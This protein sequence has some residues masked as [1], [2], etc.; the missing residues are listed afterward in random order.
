MLFVGLVMQVGAFEKANYAEIWESIDEEGKY[1]MLIGVISSSIQDAILLTEFANSSDIRFIE[2]MDFIMDYVVYIAKYLSF[3]GED[4]NNID[5]VI[6]LVDKFYL[7]PNNKYCNVAGL[8]FISYL[9]LQGKDVSK[10]LER[11]I[12]YSEFGTGNLF[13]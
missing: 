12:Y 3:Y 4:M 5:K 7:D 11:L 1:L 6:N 13:R 9:Q 2:I 8:A 10:E